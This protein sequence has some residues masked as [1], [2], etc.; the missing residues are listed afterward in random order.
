MYHQNASSS[1]KEQ[2]VAADYQFDRYS[3]GKLAT[4]MPTQEVGAAQIEH[5]FFQTASNPLYESFPLN[6]TKERFPHPYKKCFVLLSSWYR[7]SKFT[8]SRAHRP[9]SSSNIICNRPS[10]PRANIVLFELSLSSFLS[11]FLEPLWTFTFELPFKILRTRRLGKSFH[12]VIKNVSFPFTINVDTT[13]QHHVIIFWY[14]NQT[15]LFFSWIFIT[16]R[17]LWFRKQETGGSI[18]MG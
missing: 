7:I 5:S 15:S 2:S 12:T 1:E 6:V 13:R 9:V 10:P 16:K 17:S 14:T 18:K 4:F 8:S 11:K 3:G